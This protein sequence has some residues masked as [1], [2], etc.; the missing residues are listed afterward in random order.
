MMNAFCPLRKIMFNSYDVLTRKTR[1]LHMN[2]SV[3]TPHIEHI[4]RR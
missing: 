4:A 2:K 3:P 1:A